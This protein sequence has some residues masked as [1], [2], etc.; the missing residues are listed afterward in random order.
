MPP[1]QATM[2]GRLHITAEG[3]FAG[4]G[5]VFG[6]MKSALKPTEAAWLPCLRFWSDVR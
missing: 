6:G 3:G 4:P 5:G 2:A 1:A